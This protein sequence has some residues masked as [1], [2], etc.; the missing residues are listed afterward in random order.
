MKIR[1]LSIFLFTFTF[2]VIFSQSLYVPLEF[3]E[4]YEN[5]TRSLDGKPGADYWQNHA[6]YKIKANLNDNFNLE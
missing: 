3:Q 1:I 6:D 5:G 4:A 2:S